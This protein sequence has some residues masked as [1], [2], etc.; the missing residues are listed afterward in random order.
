MT[1]IASFTMTAHFSDFIDAQIALGRYGSVD[2][3]VCAGLR[4]LEDQ[5]A[6]LA[7]L[8]AALVAG[9][10]SGVSGRSVPEIWDAVKAGDHIP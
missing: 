10:E 8:R 1:K 6:R 4:L 5:E 2:D 3:V 9:E 7:G